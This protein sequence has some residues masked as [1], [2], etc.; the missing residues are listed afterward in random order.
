MPR[1]KNTELKRAI[2][3][4]AWRQFREHGYVDTTYTSIAEECGISRNLVQ[5]HLPSKDLLAVSFMQELLS[6]CEQAVADG[7]PAKDDFIQK[8]RNAFEVGCCFYSVLMDCGY[9]TF[10]MEVLSDRELS[11]KIL[12]YDE[13]WAFDYFGIDNLTDQEKREFS[14]SVILH[15]GGFLELMYH[16]LKKGESFDIPDNLAY[17]MLPIAEGL[18]A[19]RDDASDIF[20]GCSLGMRLARTVNMGKDSS[21]TA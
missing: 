11:D 13:T 2:Q 14:R 4:A 3:Q 8:C 21:I 1:P 18:G 10:L 20:E 9:R 15:T 16:S 5:Y 19:D 17:A 12:S 6:R 7:Q